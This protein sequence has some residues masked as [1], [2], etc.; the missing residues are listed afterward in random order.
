MKNCTVAE[1]WY[2]RTKPRLTGSNM[3]FIGDTIYSYGPHFPMAK[4]INGAV[5]RNPRRYSRSTTR[6]QGYVNQAI[7][8]GKIIVDLDVGRW[9]E[10]E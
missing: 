1:H 3:Y 2:N 7:G 10:F 5:L 4:L 9:N 6:H 8:E